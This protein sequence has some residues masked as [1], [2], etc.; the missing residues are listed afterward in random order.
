MASLVWLVNGEV[1]KKCQFK[2]TFAIRMLRICHVCCAKRTCFLDLSAVNFLFTLFWDLFSSP[3]FNL[4]FILYYCSAYF[5]CMI[6]V[7]IV[8]CIWALFRKLINFP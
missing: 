5:P 4:I 6:R 1:E 8:V 7:N 2:V 3:K